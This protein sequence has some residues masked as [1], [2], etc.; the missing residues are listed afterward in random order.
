[1]V[2]PGAWR[3]ENCFKT[4][5]NTNEHIWMDVSF[6]VW[7][8]WSGPH[9]VKREYCS[10]LLGTLFGGYWYWIRSVRCQFF[11]LSFDRN[12]IA[13]L[14]EDSLWSRLSTFL[15]NMVF[16]DWWKVTP[17]W[18]QLLLS[19]FFLKVIDSLFTNYYYM[20]HR[21]VCLSL[22]YERTHRTCHSN[23]LRRYYLQV[24]YLQSEAHSTTR[25]GE[26][27]LSSMSKSYS[28]SSFSITE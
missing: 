17:S 6:S 2:T 21:Y 26:P 18:S 9:I 16:D 22:P 5:Q 13:N 27:I 1:M 28:W 20:L 14:E 7:Y 12:M 19:Y 8:H 24:T 10:G 11:T 25:V 4:R 23:V 3:I 15:K